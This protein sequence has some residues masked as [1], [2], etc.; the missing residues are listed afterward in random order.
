[1]S[2]FIGA[3]AAKLAGLQKDLLAKFQAGHITLTHLEWF[4]CLTKDQRDQLAGGAIVMAERRI[5]L[6]DTDRQLDGW[7]D[8]WKR[9]SNVEVA[10][11]KIQVPGHQ[12]GFDQ[13]IVMPEEVRMTNNGIFDL[14]HRHLTCW[15]YYDD[16]D[17]AI[18]HHDRDPNQGSYAIWV[19][20]RQEADEE[21]KNLSARYF[22]DQ[23]LKTETY[24]ERMVHG[25]NYWDR[26][27]K[28]LDI[29]NWTLCPGSRF[30]HGGVPI[31][32]R[33]PDYRKVKVLYYSPGCSDHDIRARSAVS[34]S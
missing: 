15:R 3:E 27:K 1:M 6:P 25:L 19:R 34:S 13:L 16:L 28:H 4:N 10:T 31:V 32:D 20:D 8:F 12:P 2:S 11:S 18:C 29:D 21:N 30:G 9:Y 5:V 24:L 22:W 7:K 33:D 17:K 23:K 14:C 26:T